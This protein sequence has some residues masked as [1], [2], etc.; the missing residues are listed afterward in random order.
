MTERSYQLLGTER[1][2]IMGECAMTSGLP[3]WLAL[4]RWF[5]WLFEIHEPCGYTPYIIANLSMAEI[6]IVLSAVF[7]LVSVGMVVWLAKIR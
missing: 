6:L 2:W 1:G 3:E 4:E 5:P 7:S